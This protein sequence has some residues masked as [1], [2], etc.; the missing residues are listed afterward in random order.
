MLAGSGERVA[1]LA[2]AL[3]EELEVRASERD[4]IYVA[5]LLRDVGELGIDRRVLE[6]PGELIDDQREL[7]R[8]H[9]ALGE[10]IIGALAFLGDAPRIIRAHHERWDGTGYPDHLAEEQ[11]PLGAR[12]LS[13]ADAFVAM[14]SERPYRAALRPTEALGLLIAARGKAFDPAVVDIFVRLNSAGSLGSLVGPSD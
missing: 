2:A 13:V 7:V 6:T 14:T 1:G 9:P 8:R 11:I 5:A 12:I 10:A 4:D 3:A